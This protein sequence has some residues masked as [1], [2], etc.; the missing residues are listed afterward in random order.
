M[1]NGW[2]LEKSIRFFL[3]SVSDFINYSAWQG[4]TSGQHNK[5]SKIFAGGAVFSLSFLGLFDVSILF[6]LFLPVLILS[7]VVCLFV[8]FVFVTIIAF[9]SLCKWPSP[10]TCLFKYHDITLIISTLPLIP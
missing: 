10:L 7:V 6:V 1:C 9:P 2:F 4:P 8:L 5:D 3:G